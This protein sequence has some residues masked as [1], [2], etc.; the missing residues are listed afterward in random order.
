[1]ASAGWRNRRDSPRSPRNGAPYEVEVLEDE[2][3][4]EAQLPAERLAL[5]LAGDPALEHHRDGV[6]GDVQHRRDHHRHAGQGDEGEQ[7]PPL[8]VRLHEEP[9]VSRDRTAAPPGDRRRH[10]GAGDAAES[11]DAY[12]NETSSN[13]ISSSERAFQLTLLLAP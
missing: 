1:M 13:V 7:D 4:V 9:F 2:G 11:P 10:R 12:L 3:L 5:G 8:E 6:A